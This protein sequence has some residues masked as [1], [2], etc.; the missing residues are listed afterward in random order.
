[1]FDTKG[2]EIGQEVTLEKG[3]CEGR[4]SQG[5]NGFCYSVEDSIVAKSVRSER[6]SRRT[7]ARRRAKQ[8]DA[9]SADRRMRSTQSYLV[10]G[11][12]QKV[13]ELREVIEENSPDSS[14]VRPKIL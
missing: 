11:W 6:K 8:V 7:R 2:S 10:P 13:R 12:E 4:C 9:E 3:D 1:M 14:P 5:V